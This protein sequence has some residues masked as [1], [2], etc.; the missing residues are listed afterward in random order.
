MDKLEKMKNSCAEFAQDLKTG[1]VVWNYFG[2]KTFRTKVN[3][4]GYLNIFFDEIGLQFILEG[5]HPNLMSLQSETAKEAAFEALELVKNEAQKLLDALS[6]PKEEMP[7][8]KALYSK[9]E[10]EF[11]ETM[12]QHKAHMAVR[13][14]ELEDFLQKLQ[15]EYESNQSHWVKIDPTYL[16]SKEVF[17]VNEEGEGISG[18]IVKHNKGFLMCVSELDSISNPT[19]YLEYETILK[20]IPKP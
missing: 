19:H 20:L 5:Y 18:Q 3:I 17:A 9:A 11:W 15:K 16:P 7:K 10:K 12:K 1:N 14:K 6:E 4:F 13:E 2:L 8:T